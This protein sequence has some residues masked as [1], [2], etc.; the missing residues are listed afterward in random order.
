MKIISVNED[1]DPNDIVLIEALTHYKLEFLTY[2]W[3]LKT[4]YI[5][6]PQIFQEESM[7]I[8]QLD[9]PQE[10]KE[11]ILIK[12]KIENLMTKI[13]LMVISLD[14]NIV[15]DNDDIQEAY[16]QEEDLSEIFYSNLNKIGSP[17]IEI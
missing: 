7:T 17:S 11:E 1:Y 4:L 6:E 3:I 5:S 15:D 12:A 10:M 14:L 2:N 13:Y 8:I 9:L 16:N